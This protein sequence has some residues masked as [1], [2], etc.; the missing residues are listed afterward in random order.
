MKGEMF[1]YGEEERKLEW[2]ANRRKN[3]YLGIDS[4]TVADFGWEGGA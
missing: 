4:Y 3:V 1:R 2:W